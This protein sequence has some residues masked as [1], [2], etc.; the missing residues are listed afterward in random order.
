M[1][2][3]SFSYTWLNKGKSLF[4]LCA[5][6]PSYIFTL[7]NYSRFKEVIIN[8]HFI[9]IKNMQQLDDFLFHLQLLFF[10]DFLYFR[11]LEDLNFVLNNEIFL[12]FTYWYI[13]IDIVTKIWNIDK[14]N[15]IENFFS[16]CR[17]HQA[18]IRKEQ[19]TLFE[20]T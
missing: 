11:T 2:Y 1:Q 19:R 9:K 18:F 5:N 14:K 10:S 13:I 12:I 7:F 20:N 6:S 16:M 15:H 3:Y 17:Y 8:I 4:I